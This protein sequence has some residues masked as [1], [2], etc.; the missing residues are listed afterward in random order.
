MA[1]LTRHRATPNLNVMTEP[2]LKLNDDLLQSS[3]SSEYDGE[4]AR[5]LDIAK[6]VEANQHTVSKHRAV[7]QN[8]AK[9]VKKQGRQLN[10]VVERARD[11]TPTPP[12]LQI[13]IDK[14][15]AS[16]ESRAKT[17]RPH[18]AKCRKRLD[19]IA[20]SN[21]PWAKAWQSIFEIWIDNAVQE[22]EQI[23]DA[24]VALTLIGAERT[25]DEPGAIIE[26]DDDLDG[27]FKALRSQ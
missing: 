26:C 21:E 3:A 13:A 9:F 5:L 18:L 7:A 17:L 25:N 27:Y 15:A 11:R 16:E 2:A 12:V 22:L 1:T 10:R 23:R 14:C 19:A 6:F 20:A 24:R 4:L 8:Y